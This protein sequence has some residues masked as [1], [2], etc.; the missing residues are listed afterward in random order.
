[1]NF[2]DAGKFLLYKYLLCKTSWGQGS[3]EYWYYIVDIYA[4]VF[5]Y[6]CFFENANELILEK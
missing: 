2:F 1:M 6:F 5:Y 4:F 3:C